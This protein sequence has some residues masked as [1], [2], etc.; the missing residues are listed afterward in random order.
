MDVNTFRKQLQEVIP[1]I[2][3][4]AQVLKDRDAI[5]KHK[6]KP[7]PKPELIPLGGVNISFSHS[8]FVKVMFLCL[9]ALEIVT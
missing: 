1:L 6:Q 4:V 7:Y 9:M 2:T 8:G 5:D 3:T